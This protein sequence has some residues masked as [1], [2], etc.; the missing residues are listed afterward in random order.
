MLDVSSIRPA[1]RMIQLNQILL[2]NHW[3]LKPKLLIQLKKTD[4][5]ENI[6]TVKEGDDKEEGEKERKMTYFMTF[7]FNH[8]Q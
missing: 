7:I 2:M 8:V 1:K 4:E 6:L 3:K 5:K